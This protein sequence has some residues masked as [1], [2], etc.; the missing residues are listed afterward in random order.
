MCCGVLERSIRRTRVLSSNT[1]QHIVWG[2][3]QCLIY[4]DGYIP[5]L[6][7]RHPAAMGRAFRDVW[8][9]I[10]NEVGP[11]VDKTYAGEASYFKDHPWT[12]QRGDHGW[13]L[14]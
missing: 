10:W 4:N 13:S 2:A 7:D 1:P 11:I 8:P 6:G 5:V 3:A 12:L 14:K 9:D